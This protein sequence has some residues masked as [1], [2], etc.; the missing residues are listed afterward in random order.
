MDEKYNLT[1][2]QRSIEDIQKMESNTKNKFAVEVVVD[3]VLAHAERKHARLGGSSAHRW[4]NCAGS[5]ALC[6]TLPPQETSEAAARGTYV[7]EACE[8]C[9]RNFLNHKVTGESSAHDWDH[10]IDDEACETANNY[11]DVVW[12]EVLEQSLTGKAWGIEEEVCLDE[13]LQ[14][15]GIVDFWVVY[16]NDQGKRVLCIVDFKNGRRFVDVPKNEQFI[17]YGCAMIQEIRNGGKDI[18]VLRTCVYQPNC[19][20]GAAPFR[21]ASY[22]TKQIDTWFKKFYKAGRAVFEGK[23][24]FK[25][26]EWC[27]DCRAQG[28]C[29]AYGATISDKS[30]LALLETKEIVL[31]KPESIPPE[32]AAAIALHADD[33]IEFIKAVKANAINCAKN[34]S[35]LPGTKVVNG[36]APRRAWRDEEEEVAKSLIEAGIKNPWVSKL[37]TITAAEK[38]I[39]A[40]K[41]IPCVKHTKQSVILVPDTDPRPAIKSAIDVLKEA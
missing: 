24:K 19:S 21:E 13:K 39:G 12:K 14:M 20:T 6:E 17:F 27:G 5:V 38:I 29:K 10:D 31:P 1:K 35:A 15:W 28:V 30:A 26:G 8:R 16:I 41:L 3:R 11:V 37:M 18:D 22:T 40:E 9:L 7:H 25:V 36:P 33:I 34:G 32:R 4:C 23:A 2:N